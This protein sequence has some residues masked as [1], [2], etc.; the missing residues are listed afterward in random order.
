MVVAVGPHTP[1]LPEPPKV[2]ME[3]EEYVRSEL[4]DHERFSNREPLDD[5]GVYSLHILA[6]RI[7]AMGQEDGERV[8][9]ERHRG[10]RARERDRAARARAAAEAAEA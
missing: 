5:S 8:A 7:Y 9:G 6:A 3:V 1:H 10:E 2:A 4:N